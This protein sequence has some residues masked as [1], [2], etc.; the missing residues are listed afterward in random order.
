[1]GR[2]AYDEKVRRTSS[3][4]WSVI[5]SVAMTILLTFMV[6]PGLRQQVVD[7]LGHGSADSTPRPTAKGTQTIGLPPPPGTVEPTSSATGTP[8]HKGALTQAELIQI[9]KNA[10]KRAL[11]VGSC[12]VEVR[13]APLGG[14]A[15]LTDI[16]GEERWDASTG[17]RTST[18]KATRI[19]LDPLLLDTNAT[20]AEHVATH[21]WNHV[22]EA[23]TAG[24]SAAYRAIQE[25]ANA[26]F[27]PRAKVDLSGTSTGMELL[28]DCMTV[29]QDDALAG[30]GREGVTVY[31]RQYLTS[32]TMDAACGTGWQALLKKG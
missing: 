1:V 26:Y 30:P 6:N 16:E 8:D 18:L 5:V 28:T 24:S 3:L 22:E 15:G 19:T 20:Y 32:K 13:V 12:D 29:F 17:N 21:E 4:L 9:A 14:P 2:G 27:Q 25:R 10:C 11:D 23:N 31:V 7:R